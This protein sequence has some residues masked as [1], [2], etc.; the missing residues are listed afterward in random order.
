MIFA[1]QRP[2]PHG[3]ISIITW[4]RVNGHNILRKVQPHQH[5]SDITWTQCFH[6]HHQAA[7]K[8]STITTHTRLGGL[9][10]KAPQMYFYKSFDRLLNRF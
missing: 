10:I 5:T 9:L 4:Y 6:T 7:H 3:Q 8:I 1:R 2:A